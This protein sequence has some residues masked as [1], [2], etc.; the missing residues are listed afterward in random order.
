LCYFFRKRSTGAIPKKGRKER[1]N[2]HTHIG[3][4]KLQIDRKEAKRKT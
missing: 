1:K 4:A 3:K 2:G